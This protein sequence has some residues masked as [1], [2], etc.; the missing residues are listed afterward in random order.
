MDVWW[1]ELGYGVPDGQTKDYNK[2]I[3][4]IDVKDA[5]ITCYLTEVSADTSAHESVE[6]VASGEAAPVP[7][8]GPGGGGTIAVPVNVTGQGEVLE[9]GP[10][11]AKVFISSYVTSGEQKFGIWHVV[12]AE[13]VT[14]VSFTLRV[15]SGYGRAV[16]MIQ[17]L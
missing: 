17:S 13:N 7:V 15:S 9:T 16:G 11:L 6:I 12:R 3:E 8:Y 2:F 1:T 5:L 10:V 14:F 4:D